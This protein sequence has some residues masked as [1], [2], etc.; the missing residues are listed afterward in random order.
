MK[1][2]SPCW[3][4]ISERQHADCQIYKVYEQK[5]RHPLDGRSGNFYVINCNDWV[6]ILPLTVVG[7][8][9]LVNQY[10]FGS[11]KSSWEVPGGVMD[12][13]E[14]RAEITAKR[15][16]LE[17]TGYMGEAG[18]LIASN[19]PNPALQSNRVHFVLIKNCLQISGQNLDPNEEIEVQTVPIEKVFQMVQTHE[20]NHGIT[21]N[22]L[23][24]FKNY[25]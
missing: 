24:Y 22:A 11:R 21:I 17:E 16:L 3:K 10:R 12:D 13:D 1:N 19:Y 7:E 14:S 8:L 23:F 18:K 9:I 4:I 25:L 20:I 15:E 5:C 6:T 2:K